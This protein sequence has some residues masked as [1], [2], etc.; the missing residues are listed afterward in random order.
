MAKVHDTS[1]GPF[2][3]GPKAKDRN[4]APAAERRSFGSFVMH[5]RRSQGTPYLTGVVKGG[6]VKWPDMVYEC[7]LFKG[8]GEEG[9]SCIG[10]SPDKRWIVAGGNDGKIY[11]KDMS[12]EKVEH[13]ESNAS[14][15]QEGKGEDDEVKED[16]DVK[17]VE[18]EGNWGK[19]VSS[20]TF[21]QDEGSSGGGG[22]IVYAGTNGGN[23]CKVGLTLALFVVFMFFINM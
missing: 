20:L 8:S 21:G 22:S 1:E 19:K 6:S 17:T 10:V 11:I 4:P 5:T 2:E 7:T 23:L 16:G 12:E 14:K 3:T 9:F 13:D 15:A 18:A